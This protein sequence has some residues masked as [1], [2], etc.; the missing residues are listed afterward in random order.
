MLRW[1]GADSGPEPT[2]R[3]VP[4]AD[5]RTHLPRDTPLVMPDQRDAAIRARRRGAQWRRRW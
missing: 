2:I 4:A 3:I 5:V 1:T